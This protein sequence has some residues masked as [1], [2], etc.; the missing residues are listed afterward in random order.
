MLCVF[1]MVVAA[2]TVSTVLI[3]LHVSQVE[4]RSKAIERLK[5]ARPAVAAPSSRC[6]LDG[7]I[8]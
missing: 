6:K 7:G 5:T 4:T 3:R 8:S 1:V 2:L